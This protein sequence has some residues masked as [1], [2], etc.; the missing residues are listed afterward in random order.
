M[1]DHD[2]AAGKRW[3]VELNKELEASNYGIL[4]L[5]PENIA[6]PWLLFE[7]GALAKLVAS[8]RV[9]PYLLF[10]P[11]IT[12]PLSQFQG[13]NADKEGTLKLVRGINQNL[14]KPLPDDRISRIFERAW[15]DLERKLQATSRPSS[16]D[17]LRTW[18]KEVSDQNSSQ[19][20]VF[21]ERLSPKNKSNFLLRAE[22]EVID[23]GTTLNTCSEYLV[24]TIRPAYYREAVLSLLDKGVNY[25][26]VILDPES[27]VCEYYGRTRNE[28]LREK[29]ERSIK[30][31]EQF[32]IDA[33]GKPGQFSV[34]AY[35]KMP[36]FSV[37][38]IDRNDDGLLL[39]SSYL[40]NAKDLS[41]GRADTPHFLLPKV[42][43][44]G[45][46]T[47]LNSCIDFYLH[48]ARSII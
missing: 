5:T 25:I 19:L 40:P 46:F 8:S 15:P 28:N 13:V 35:N 26:C 6:A 48:G 42:E 16:G 32:A 47:Q 33:K 29:T 2:I 38:A 43:S 41:I 36:Y 1:S 44:E 14:D 10:N 34:V 45:I 11:N 12:G 18:M 20:Q 37:I 21:D 3:G 31:L 7:A 4:C 30:R 23:L 27:E 9:V 24:T 22:Q 39:V 17:H